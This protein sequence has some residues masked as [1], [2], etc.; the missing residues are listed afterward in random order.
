MAIDPRFYELVKHLWRGGRFGYFWSPNVGGQ[1]YSYWVATDGDLKVPKLFHDVDA[2]FGVHAVNLRRSEHERARSQ[3][4]TET[5]CL[6]FEFDCKTD[7]ERHTALARIDALPFRL[8]ALVS[9]GGGYHGYVAL[10]SPLRGADCKAYQ[11]AMSEFAGGDTNVKDLTR[12]LRIPGTYNHKPEYAPDLPAV[13]FL[14]FDMSIQYEPQELQPWLQPLID[15]R[16]ARKAHTPHPSQPSGAVSL[17]DQELLDVLFRSKNGDTYRRLW[18]GDLSPAGGDHSKADMMLCC[19][20]AWL[21]GRDTIRMDSLFRQSGLMR[22][23]WNRDTYREDTL[24]E[25]A[26]TA[27]TVYDPGYVDPAVAA[28][29]AAIPPSGSGGS[30]AGGGGTQPPPAGGGKGQGKGRARSQVNYPTIGREYMQRNPHT[31]YTRS[32]W[33]RY[34]GGVWATFNDLAIE[35]EVWD[36]LEQYDPFPTDRGVSNITKFV[37]SKQVKKDE[38]MDADDTLINLRNGTYSLD[39]HALLTHQPGHYITTQLPFDYDPQATCPNWRRY[40]ETT[41]VDRTGQT[42]PEL[43]AFIQEA[44]GYSLTTDIKH[45]ATFWCYGEGANGKGVLFYILERLAGDSAIPFNVD[46]LHRE[47]YQLADLAGKRI[48]LC[49][50]AETSGVVED[51]IIKALVA[52]DSLQVRQIRREPF[53]LR[54][55]VKLWW[56]MNKLPTITDTSVGMWR[57]LRLIPFNADFEN[58]DRAK[59][60]DNLRELLLDEL[61]GIFNWAMEGLARL[62]VY[63]TFTHVRQIEEMTATYRRESNT[64]AA[65]VEETCDTDRSYNAGSQVIYTRY[66]EW[67]TDNGYKPY[68][69]RNFKTEM[70][71]LGYYYRR[72]NVARIFD[73]LRLKGQGNAIP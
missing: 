40:L 6:Y 10:R 48:A 67:C 28:A 61:P 54:P 11:Y 17:S 18:D 45:H 58:R 42:D 5:W 52:G 60:I 16:A 3:D 31:I 33:L 49:P 29:Q 24:R 38:E 26:D 36:L 30:G 65:F 46:L 32:R 37:R 57:R 20:L 27:Q 15:A 44:M 55:T 39:L 12:V 72:A 1:K 41:F 59:R 63:K 53:T 14:Q 66:K 47:Q 8:T 21:C 9:S 13:E 73:G 23:K 68:N 50:E 51:A 34:G 35:S 70:E 69:V 4:V 62:Q 25:A 22:D 2:Y 71:R 7:A 56:S 64:I 19:G 43:I